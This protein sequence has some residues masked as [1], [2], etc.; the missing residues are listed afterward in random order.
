MPQGLSVGRLI[1]TTVT[2]SP[3]AAQR[4]GF[5]TLLIINDSDV[6]SPTE[7]VRTYITLE[8]V[9]QDFGTTNPAYLAARLY[10]GQSPRPQQLQIGRWVSSGSNGFL[11]CGALSESEQL[12]TAWT[13]IT[14]ASF[15]VVLNSG[16][17]LNLSGMDFTGMANL[18]AVASLIT[19]TMETAGGQAVCTWDGERFNFASQ[20]P[21]SIS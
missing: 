16:P 17:L 18:N 7:R 1:R 10:F 8:D 14:D 13:S 20:L 15:S 12:M 21:G 2:L 19:T 11:T 3:L 4:R 9:A 5:G 6:I